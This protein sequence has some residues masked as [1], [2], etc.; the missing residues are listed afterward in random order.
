MDS[1]KQ[2]ILV[3]DDVPSNILVL[4]E[5]L[6]ADYKIFFASSGQECIEIAHMEKPDII[7]LDIMMPEMDGYEVC[8]RLKVDPVTKDIPIIFVTAMG[9]DVDETMGLEIGAI[10]YII[11][12]ISPLI[13]KAR[14]KN[15]IKL[16][17]Y[18]D[19]LKNL[20]LRDGLTGI[21]NRRHFDEFLEVEWRRAMRSSYPICLIMFD[22]DFFKRYNDDYGHLA[23]D[24]C[25]RRVAD[26][27]KATFKRAG[28]LVAR[29][30]GEEFSVILPMTD[31]EIASV[32]AETMRWK[33]ESVKIPH[34]SSEV[35]AWV[36][37]SVGAIS[38]VP[39]HDLSHSYLI[40]EADKA[41]YQAKHGGR[42]RVVFAE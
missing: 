31:R 18:Q 24:E 32:I 27:T 34:K 33:V 6:R 41:L 5:I 23:G 1:L 4:N 39:S 19:I 35:S 9:E 13:L 12:P 2:K 26:T 8:G 17:M 28:D 29:Y 25:L 16:K 42:N 3:V 15:H 22:I 37:I 14:V 21:A 40:E 30:G 36:T 38:L 7:L 11:K 10:D 20:S